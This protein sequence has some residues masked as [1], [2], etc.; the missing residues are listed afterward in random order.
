MFMKTIILAAVATA[1]SLTSFAQPYAFNDAIKLRKY[2]KGGKLDPAHSDDVK[3]ILDPYLNPGE[4]ISAFTQDNALFR[5]LIDT[6]AKRVSATDPFSKNRVPGGGATLLGSAGGLD[7]TMLADG[8]ARFMVKRAKEELNVAF[9]ERFKNEM[10]K[11]KYKDAITLFPE[12]CLTLGSIGER[13]YMYQT[14]LPA[15]QE[16]FQKDLR[17]L[18]DNLPK[19]IEDGNYRNYFN[20]NPLLKYTC[21]SG[22][23]VANAMDDGEHPGMI[24]QNFPRE[25]FNDVDN[26]TDRRVNKTAISGILATTQLLRLISVSLKAPSSNEYWHRANTI[27]DAFKD[28]VTVNIYLALLRQQGKF[29]MFDTTSLATM[30]DSLAP[31]LNDYYDNYAGVATSLAR[32]GEELQEY[33]EEAKLLK[34]KD[35]KPG[36]DLYYKYFNGMVDILDLTQQ[37][38]ELPVLEKRIPSDVKLRLP[39]YV[40]ISRSVSNLVLNVKERNFS[41]AIIN[42]YSVYNYAFDKKTIDGYRSVNTLESENERLKY[43]SRFGTVLIRTGS[44]MSSVSSAKNSED[45]SN[46][47][48]ATVLPAGSSRHKREVA[49]NISLNGY[50]GPYGGH[51]WIK[52][53]NSNQKV[54][55][56]GLLAPVG[57]AFSRGCFWRK[58]SAT[59]FISVIDVGTVASFRA[60]DSGTSQV[61]IIQLKDIVA[62]GAFLFYGIPKTPLSFGA[63]YQFG[64][65]IR[66]TDVPNAGEL[67]HRFSVTLTVDIPLLNFASWQAKR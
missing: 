59:L 11:G 5:L 40:G 22:I 15:L 66:N 62:P 61:P 25:Y 12:T 41:S 30:L 49:W 53:I 39:G 44:F 29:I 20:A 1:C 34:A 48:E 21:L 56:Y 51:E 54:N 35:Q 17:M 10:T 64:P 9:F 67:Y 65:R 55:T 36:F 32:K 7:V 2:I 46:A 42:T 23:Y 38:V 8:L 57:I 31:R 13:I 58:S 45:I 3:K 19:V 4:D 33:I 18:S 60:K 37:I 47:I 63:G 50:I 52:N 28:P 26:I 16:A 6:N 43:A 14:F 27:K 24:I